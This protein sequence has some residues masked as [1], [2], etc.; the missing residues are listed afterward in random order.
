M[1]I[2]SHIPPLASFARSYPPL[3]NI[4]IVTFKLCS[5]QLILTGVIMIKKEIIIICLIIVTLTFCCCFNNDN[6]DKGKKYQDDDY[7]IEI[8]SV[9]FT[10]N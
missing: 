7:T 10:I 2:L 8:I 5:E 9:N 1:V 6:N 4:F 3:H